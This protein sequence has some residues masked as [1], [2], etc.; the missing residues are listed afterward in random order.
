MPVFKTTDELYKVMGAL[1]ERLRST[2]EI[3]EKLAAGDLVVRFHYRD[4]DGIATIDLT[5]TP[6]EFEF[7]E[8]DREADVRMTSSADVAHEFWLGRLNVPKAIATRKVVARGSVPKALKL[9]PAIKPAFEIY[10]QVL[11]ELGYSHLLDGISPR[12]RK[13]QAR[14]LGQL[15]SRL[16]PSS[17][18]QT[19]D[20]SGL[21]PLPLEL[22][23][24][25]QI[26]FEESFIDQQLPTKEKLLKIEMMRRMWLI[27]IF[28]EALAA[29]FH[30]GNVPAEAL[31]LSIGQE[32]CA[33]GA[34]FALG[35]TDYM[36]TTH[37][38]HGH[39]I[40]KGVDLNRMM[41]E[42]FGKA[43]G[44]CKGKGGCMH[45][46]QAD[47]GALGANGIVGAS[48]LM[49]IGAAH[50]AKL[51]GVERVAL[52]FLGDGATNHGMFH[53]AV[54]FAAVFD[55]PAVFIV[56]NN[57]YAE[58]TPARDHARVTHLAERAAGYGIP[59]TTVDGND[60][61]A[62]YE[63]VSE[64]VARARRGDGPS[65][66][67]CMTYRLSGHAEGESA[68]YRTE[69]EKKAWAARCPIKR[70][71]KKL[72]SK[73]IIRREDLPGFK[74]EAEQRVQAAL[75]FARK[76][77][78]PVREELH[79]DVFSPDP[80]YLWT[81]ASP[82]TADRE[83]TFS[84]AL[85]EAM[86]EEMRRDE[87]VYLLGEDVTSGGYFAV[88]AGLVEEFGR[89]RVIDTPIS[90][91][92][93]VGSAAAAAMTGMRPIAEIQFSDFLTCCMDPLV[94][95][96]PKL[97]Y[98]TGGQFRLPLV[99]RTPGGAGIGMAAQ[100]SQSL[101]A[102]LMGIPGWIIVAPGTAADAKGLLKAAIRSNNPVLFFEN[103]L[104]YLST[105]QVS[106]EDYI[107]PL[108]VAEVKRP[109]TDAT[110]IA[111]GSMVPVALEAAAA[112]DQ[113]GISVEV[114][115]PRT[116]VPTDWRTLLGSVEKTRRLVVAEEGHL[117]HGFGS[118]VV[119]RA[120]EYLHGVLVAPPQRVAA[121]D[122][123]IPYNRALENAVV[124]DQER[125]VE[126]VRKVMEIGDG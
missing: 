81:P 94:N 47:V 41:A 57:Q 104:L 69:E 67:E 123:P 23:D 117:T 120:C 65:I 37:R 51:R 40:A 78:E 110:I 106:E 43:E 99:V 58:F 74:E 86:A 103:K 100:H 108:G 42:I 18:P 48:A 7:G 105:G 113:D 93:I 1:F 92:A 14:G 109:G 76:S 66:I 124:P 20:L 89:Q 45:V 80:R 61:W 73:K 31:H 107:V 22:V 77:Q 27:R 13:R 71:E 96:I 53:E 118:E 75:E 98:M 2:P 49:C 50:S 122:V 36:T 44:S 19:S 3:A 38:G 30:A 62:V 39:L 10:P 114:V 46:A 24:V 125:L 88:T 5:R 87:R 126:A 119:A 25:D 4:P 33:V 95:Q 85:Q 59:G 102:L 83:I 72:L 101:E 34:C 28:E 54:N 32:A 17:R 6:I 56:E 111:L 116:I 91:Y 60:V 8:S 97:R 55:L 11:R 64:A 12:P 29:E 15:L 90:E 16:R 35:S 26:E 9:L 84:Q 79:R 115:D 63:A 21:P 112:L 82:P 70:W 68:V 52:C 121:L